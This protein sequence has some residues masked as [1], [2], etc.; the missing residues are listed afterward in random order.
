MTTS[1]PNEQHTGLTQ[2]SAAPVDPARLSLLFDVLLNV[3]R[4]DDEQN[5]LRDFSSQL[6]WV[7]DFDRCLFGFPRPDGTLECHSSAAN[8]A[9]VTISSSERELL[10]KVFHEG[11]S[12]RIEQPDPEQTLLGLPLKVAEKPTGAVLL[13]SDGHG[14]FTQEDIRLAHAVTTFLALAL[15]RLGRIAALAKSNEELRF[16]HVTTLGDNEGQLQGSAIIRESGDGL[17]GIASFEEAL[18]VWAQQARNTIGA[19]QVALSYMPPGKF[20]EGKHAISMS[21]KY[22]KYKTYDVLPT[23]EGIWGLIVEK[24]LSFCLTQAELESHPDWKNFSDMRDARGLEHPPMRGWLAVP[25]LQHDGR[26]LGVLQATDKYDGEFDEHDLQLFNR[27]ARM[28][29][30]SFALQAANEELA[31]EQYLLQTLV[32]TVP[33]PVFFKDLEGRFTRVNQAMAH[34]AGFDD[35][36]QLIGKTDVDIWSGDLPQESNDDERHIIETGE[37]LINKEE[38]PVAAGGPLRWVLVTKMPLRDENGVIVG[39]FGISRDITHQKQMEHSLRDARDAAESANRAKSAFLANM[40]HEIRTPMNGIIGMSELLQ[41]TE[42]TS[43]QREYVAAAQESA[44]SL[45]RLL[46]ELL[47]LSR[48]EAG[49]MELDLVD[50]SVN[51]CVARAIRTLAP[52]AAAR[53]L[54]LACRIAPDVPH[55]V[56]GDTG[57]LRQILVNLI[58]NAVKFTAAGEV[59][60]DVNLDRTLDAV[61]DTTTPVRLRIS[62]RDTGPGIPFD[63]QQRIFETFQ[64]ADSSSTRKFGGTG[65]G[66][67]VSAKLVQMMNGRLRVESE[68][69]HGATFHF[70]AEFGIAIEPPESTARRA[71]IRELSELPV[72]VVDDN[73]TNRRILEELLILWNCKPMLASDGAAGVAL[74]REAMNAGQPYRLV[75]LDFNMPEMD[76]FQMAEQLNETSAWKD[77]AVIMLLS[78]LHPSEAIRCR[79]LGIDRFLTKPVMSSELFDAVVEQ[80]VGRTIQPQE[81]AFPH[82]VMANR[83]RILLVEDSKVNQMVVVGFLDYRGDETCVVENGQEA[84]DILQRES[85]DVVLMD[86]QMPVMNGYEAM[87]RI[88]EQERATGQHQSIIALTAEAMKGDRIRCLSAGADLYLSKPVTAEQLARALEGTPTGC[89]ASQEIDATLDVAGHRTVDGPPDSTSALINLDHTRE[90]IP[91]GDAG[92]RDLAAVCADECRRLLP[93][94]EAAITAADAPL[95]NRL[96]HT[97]KSSARYFGATTVVKTAQNLELIGREGRLDESAAD[98]PKLKALVERLITELQAIS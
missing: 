19:H 94:L 23:G 9:A 43:R 89:L 78:S 54:E 57:R 45:M 79:E 48:I 18:D 38:S 97:I 46:N 14:A 25:I 50:F 82:P 59:V 12:R 22:D 80:I 42:L 17:A 62:V 91:G 10:A 68:E 69:G 39:T 56:N 49:R 85:F 31:R 53:D 67:A 64:Q 8:V 3:A 52:Q 95:I 26:F 74:F 6:A 73:A 36:S 87:A 47:D 44:Q 33:D 63:Q 86:M 71:E 5:L 35:P 92:I 27:L 16:A 83:R 72:L 29:A 84:L 7:L 37:P 81:A 90:L 60:V 11:A 1:D 58:G 13:V 96:A 93:E 75:L 76:G 61:S 66:L 51:D 65:L 41:R 88:R 77:C 55:W 32:E 30:P 98:F 34:D 15:D 28:V 40:S 4:G 20:A 24:Q 2:P 70:V 21:E